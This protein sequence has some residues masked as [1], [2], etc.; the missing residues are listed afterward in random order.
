MNATEKVCQ[1]S[2]NLHVMNELIKAINEQVFVMHELK[3]RFGCTFNKTW[4]YITRLQKAVGNLQNEINDLDPVGN[5]TLDHLA[6]EMLSDKE[7]YNDW[8]KEKKG[9]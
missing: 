4:E 5:G 6:K 7:Y 8:K 2:S 3:Y 1:A 9:K